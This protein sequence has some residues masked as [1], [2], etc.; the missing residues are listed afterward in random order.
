MGL[1][2]LGY[3]EWTGQQ[4]PTWTRWAVIS[5]MAIQAAWKSRWVRRLL[6]LACV[7]I[8]WYGLALFAW[9]QSVQYPQ[10]QRMA[11]E[12]IQQLNSTG[13]VEF[14]VQGTEPGE[15]RHAVWSM[16]LHSYFRNPQAV[17]MVLMIGLIA[18]PLISQDVRSRAF[19]LYFSRPL[20]RFDYLLGKSAAVWAYLLLIS[21][22]PA[23][24]LYLMGTLLSTRLDVLTMSWDLPFRILLASAVLVVPTT[25]LALMLSSMTQESRYAAFAWFAV[26]IFGWIAFSVMQ[27]VEISTMGAQAFHNRNQDMLLWN[28]N[29]SMLS[30]F[31]VL[32]RVQ[33]WAF[34]FVPF[35][36]V[37]L[38][39]GV[40][41]ALTVIS[42]AILYR[43]V[44]A[45][46]R[47]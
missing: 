29:W 42:Q 36:D 9:E 7:P 44:S 15:M 14:R 41:V 11:L 47:A 19:L 38:P 23:L 34:G 39:A 16:L 43:R 37:M 22:A 10:W 4:A 35:K 25:S 24:L 33:S 12:L 18:P 21:A 45:P 5:Q 20:D 26:W 13:A 40:L 46:L 2:N 32:G 28:S 1:H 27:T 31:H 17:L 6:F 30:L 8:F 3:R